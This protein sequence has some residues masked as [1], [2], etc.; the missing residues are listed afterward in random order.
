MNG[1]DL[2]TI[3]RSSKDLNLPRLDFVATKWL[4]EMG[5]AAGALVQFLPEPDGM[6]FT[7]CNENI[8]NF[9]EL[10][11]TTKEKGGTLVQIHNQTNGT[12]LSLSGEKLDATGLVYK[13]KLLVRY[14]YG[15]IR[16]RKLPFGSVKL[17]IGKII[18]RW[19]AELGFVHN[20]VLSMASEHGL[21]TCKLLE[22]EPEKIKERTAELV[23]Y[24]RKNKLNLLQVKKSRNSSG[25]IN[26]PDL[27]LE[28]AGFNPDDVLLAVYEND[29]IK[30]QKPDFTALGF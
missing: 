14:K 17:S 12:R 18:G 28:K 15:F 11:Y 7:L 3:T 4:G 5:F 21:I 24:A 26:I 27:C 20:A 10:Y 6:T 19:L 8:R 25:V 23:K 2:A 1:V 16:M 29:T 30:L 13:D 22:N 9:S